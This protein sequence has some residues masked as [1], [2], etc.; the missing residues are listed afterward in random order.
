MKIMRKSAK[1]LLATILLS[2][3][4]T[5]I[6]YSE[7]SSAKAKSILEKTFSKYDA[8]FSEDMKGVNSAVVKINI[9][10]EGSINSQSGSTPPLLLDAKIEL[11][12]AQP[13]KMFLNVTGNLGNL[14]VVVP[15]KKPMTAT[16]ILPTTKQFAIMPIS[17]KTLG[18][19]QPQGREKFW[20]ETTVLYGGMQTI[21]EKQ[22]HKIILKSNNPKQKENVFLYILDKKWDPVRL[23]IKDPNGGNMVVDFEELKLNVPIPP[24]TFEPKTSGYTQVSK[25]QFTGII[26]MQIMTSAMQSNETR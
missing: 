25:E 13:N 23:E 20:V 4:L 7:E 11:Y 15:D 6:A 16:T 1:F 14:Q 2:M 10:G 12:V 26:M 21:N 8:L 24:D 22:A 18:G 17:Q 19:I 3:F 9:K 5:S